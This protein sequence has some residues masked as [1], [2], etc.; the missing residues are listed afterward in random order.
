MGGAYSREHCWESEP[1]GF[2]V[3]G[4]VSIESSGQVAKANP[5]D[6]LAQNLYVGKALFIF[7]LLQNADDNRFTKALK[8]GQQPFIAFRVYHDRAIIDCNEEGFTAENVTAICSVGQSFRPAFN[9]TTLERRDL[10]SRLHGESTFSP[11]TFL[12]TSRI[13]KKTLG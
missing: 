1:A 7:E 5:S 11:A 4:D 8:L 2:I 13:E 10:A 9:P 12:S 6:R 3:C